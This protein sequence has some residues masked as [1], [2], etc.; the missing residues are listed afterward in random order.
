MRTS[1]AACA[2]DSTPADSNRS[3]GVWLV[4]QALEPTGGVGAGT[5]GFLVG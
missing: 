4:V 5:R 1:S 2:G 3:S